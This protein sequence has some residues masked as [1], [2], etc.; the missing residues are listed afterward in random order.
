MTVTLIV[1]P[2][3]LVV[4]S[5]LVGHFALALL[6]AFGPLALVDGAILVA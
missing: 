4:V 6:H 2:V 5:S 3:A 1:V